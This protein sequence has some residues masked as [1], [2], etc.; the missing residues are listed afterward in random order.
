[1]TALVRVAALGA[2]VVA[3]IA[4]LYHLA[5]VPD[6][7]MSASRVVPA[8]ALARG[9]PLYAGPDA[10]PIIDFMYGPVAALAFLPAAFAATPSGAP[11]AAAHQK[12]AKPNPARKGTATKSGASSGTARRCGGFIK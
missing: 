11:S 12:A 10:G 6:A 9:F 4:V 3:A 8:V 1:V 2:A 5:G 7:D